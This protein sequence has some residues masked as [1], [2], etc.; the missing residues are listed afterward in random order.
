M[1]S[2][3]GEFALVVIIHI[4]AV[5]MSYTVGANDAANSLATSYGSGAAP[6]WVLLI[7]GAIFEWVGS[8][9]CSGMV[10]AKIA[11]KM[12]PTI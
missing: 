1:A 10:A 8:F 4:L 11:T 6:V 5:I 3:S 12:I 7:G 9:W 2:D